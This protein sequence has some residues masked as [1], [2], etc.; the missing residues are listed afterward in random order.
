MRV[1]TPV[2]RLLILGLVA[3]LAACGDRSDGTPEPS[4]TPSTDPVAEAPPPSAAL[5]NHE[6]VAAVLSEGGRAIL[7]APER[8]TL[9]SIEPGIWREY[10][11]GRNTEP[12]P[13]AHALAALKENKGVL[14][15]LPV[16][17][18]GERESILEGVY[19]GFIEMGP[20]AACYDP[21]HALIY[22]KGDATVAVFICFACH[23]AVILEASTET[24][25]YKAF[26]MVKGLKP[27]L[28]GLLTDAGIKLAK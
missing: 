3:V 22:E 20:E 23:Y 10:G 12:T 5:A 4:N 2:R 15:S 21:R 17:D 1:R 16:D 27:R 6:R 19:A 14:G 24:G 13:L 11:Y 25:R 9:H 18:A 26:Q 7:A 8:V 28:N